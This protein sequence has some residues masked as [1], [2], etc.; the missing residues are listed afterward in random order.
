MNGREDHT[1]ILKWAAWEAARRPELNLLFEIPTGARTVLVLVERPKSARSGLPNF[2]L[3]VARGT[4]HGLFLWR[5]PE[6]SST[7]SAWVADLRSQGYAVGTYN[8]YAQAKRII[9]TYLERL[10][11]GMAGGLRS[12]KASIPKCEVRPLRER[13]AAITLTLVPPVSM[14]RE[15]LNR[16]KSRIKRR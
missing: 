10:G 7:S 9:K 6:I 13:S 11:R 2:C 12:V 1:T 8:N 16:S 3:P 4:F 14:R 15:G 5:R